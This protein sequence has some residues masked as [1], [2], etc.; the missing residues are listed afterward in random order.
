MKHG[1]LPKG[2]DMML[3]IQVFHGIAA[4]IWVG[5]IFFAYM[6]LR[7]A[8]NITLEPAQRVKLWRSVYSHFFPWVWIMI[9]VLIIT[10]YA[11]L[12]IRFDGFVNKMLYLNLMH[13]LGLLMVVL[14]F[15]LFFGLYRDLSNQVTT[16]D[17]TAAAKVVNKMRPVMAINLTL[18][19]I[20]S[21]IGIVGPAV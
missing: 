7:P 2:Y 4:T 8:A 18:G 15:Y 3:L 21:A 5:G 1:L 13:G 10:G 17:I 9:N 11:G 6:A 16:G 14:F 19:L 12:F 20:I